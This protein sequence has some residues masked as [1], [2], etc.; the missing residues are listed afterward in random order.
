MTQNCQAGTVN[1]YVGHH[2]PMIFLD[3]VGGGV[4]HASRDCANYDVPLG[5]T[6][7]I[8]AKFTFINPNLIDDM[9]D[10]T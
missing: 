5:S 6:P 2:N 1:N 10:G 9:H 4:N 8:S 7:D 3:N